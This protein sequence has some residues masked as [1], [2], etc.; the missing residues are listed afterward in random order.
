MTAWVVKDEVLNNGDLIPGFFLHHS[1]P[2]YDSVFIN[3]DI[4][5]ICLFVHPF[6][7]RFHPEIHQITC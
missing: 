4:F 1:F 6:F 7:I 2:G 3:S 5:Y